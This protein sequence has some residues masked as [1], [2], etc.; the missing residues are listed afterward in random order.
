MTLKKVRKKKEL[1]KNITTIA[2]IA[3]ISN[4]IN[5]TRRYKWVINNVNLNKAKK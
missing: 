2:K 1:L 5:L 4:I 3:Q